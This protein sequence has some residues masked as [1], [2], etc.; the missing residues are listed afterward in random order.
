MDDVLLGIVLQ[1]PEEFPLA[2]TAAVRDRL[3]V[4]AGHGG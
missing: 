1:R 4:G 3:V 2:D